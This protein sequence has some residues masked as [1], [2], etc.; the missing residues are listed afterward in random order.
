MY[1][2]VLSETVTIAGPGHV[3]E[4]GDA[5]AAAGKTHK[6]RTCEGSSLWR[7]DS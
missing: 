3:A 7:E 5:L 1:D 6:F 4:L 2:A